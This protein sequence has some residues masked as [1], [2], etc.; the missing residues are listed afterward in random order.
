MVLEG[1]FGGV[2]VAALAGQAPQREVE[3]QPVGLGAA[4]VA[5]AL[6]VERLLDPAGGQ[7][8]AARGDLPIAFRGV[9]PSPFAGQG[10]EVGKSA[11]GA[12]PAMAV[13]AIEV[14]DGG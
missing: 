1:A 5:I 2:K 10:V 9:A 11:H 14:G 4:F 3:A 12:E 7:K 8:V 13:Q 6:L